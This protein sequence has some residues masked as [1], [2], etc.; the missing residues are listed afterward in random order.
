MFFWPFFRWNILFSF[1]RHKFCWIEK[2][3]FK[4]LG[5]QLF[6]FNIE[7]KKLPSEQQFNDKNSLCSWSLAWSRTKF[8]FETRLHEWQAIFSTIQKV[9]HIFLGFFNT[10]YYILHTQKLDGGTID[11]NIFSPIIIFVY[12][13]Y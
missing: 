9:S 4:S 11:C 8:N 13:L 3:V 2:N 6:P 1:K 10:T 12:A 5:N 7:T